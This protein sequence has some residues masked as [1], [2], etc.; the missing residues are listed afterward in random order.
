MTEFDLIQRLIPNLPTNSS[1]IAGAGHDCAVVDIGLAGEFLL[2]KTDAVVEGVHFTAETEA[3]RVGHKA[4]GRCLSDFAAMAGTPRHAMVTLGLPPGFDPEWIDGLYAGMRLLAERHG[5]AIVGGE[6]TCNPERIFISVTVTG[7]LPKNRMILR[8]GAKPGDVIFVTGELGG[9][10]LGKHLDFEPRLTEARWL[11]ENF[12]IHSMMDLSDGIAGD[13]RHILQSSGVGAELLGRAIPVS[14]A[15]RQK[16]RTALPGKGNLEIEVDTSGQALLA[17]LTDGEDFELLFT[18]GSA[19]AVPLLDAWK[20]RFST[21]K[22]S[23]VGKITV[24]PGLRLQDKFGLR[25]L[26]V[27]GYTHFS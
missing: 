5:I 2:L 27:S 26:N 4:L 20:Q 18:V 24:K 13:L 22:I 12:S 21:L 10:I 1:V 3:P 16:A 7:V 6:T 23:C 15:A 8:A 11:A 9:S 25:P 19:D 17:A 14:R